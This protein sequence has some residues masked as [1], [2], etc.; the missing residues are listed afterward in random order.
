M[1][2]QINNI[3]LERIQLKSGCFVKPANLLGSCGWAPKAW[4]IAPISKHDS[5]IT[6]FLKCNKNWST[7]EVTA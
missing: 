1:N 7:S 4:Q 5:L 2:V 6:A 3:K